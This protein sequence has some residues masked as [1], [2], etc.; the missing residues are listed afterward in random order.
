MPSGETNG[1]CPD[2]RIDDPMTKP[3][4]C[5]LCIEHRDEQQIPTVP[6]GIK[7]IM[8]SPRFAQGV[9]DARARKSFPTDYDASFANDEWHPH[10]TTT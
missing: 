8:A 7:T 5:K 10:S 2:V 1:E 9:A 3:S 6:V 4:K